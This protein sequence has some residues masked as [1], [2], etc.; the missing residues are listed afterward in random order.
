MYWYECVYVVRRYGFLALKEPS[1]K[2]GEVALKMSRF[3]EKLVLQCFFK[4][5]L[6]NLQMLLVSQLMVELPLDSPRFARPSSCYSFSQKLFIVFSEIEAWI[7]K[8]F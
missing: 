3:R 4:V 8:T 6:H 5:G 1:Q 7:Q 2:S